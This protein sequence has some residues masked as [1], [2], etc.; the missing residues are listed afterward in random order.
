MYITALTI[1]TLA[2]KMYI[3]AQMYIAPKMFILAPKMYLIAQNLH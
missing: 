3:L 1:Y 2:P